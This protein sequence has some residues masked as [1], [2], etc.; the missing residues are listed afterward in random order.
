MIRCLIRSLPLVAVLVAACGPAV[1]EDAKSAAS[2]MAA[3]R[4]VFVSGNF[5]HDK[6][7][8]D[9]IGVFKKAAD[10]GYTG[11][12]LTDCKFD[13]WNEK[14]TVSQPQYTNNVK[15]LCKG[16]RDLGLQI[17]VNCCGQGA[18]LLSNEPNLAEGMPVKDAPFLAKGGLLVPADEDYKVRNPSFEEVGRD[19]NVPVGWN[20]DFPGKCGFVDKD[21]K[22][23][24]KQSVRYE[25][26]K[27]NSSY[28]N[29]RVIQAI[30]CK[31][32]RYYHVSF[33]VKTQDFD[34]PR[35]FNAMALGPKQCLV[36]QTF[37]IKP[38]QDWTKIDIVFNTLDNTQAGLYI[39][40]WGGG[41]GK[42]WIDDVR[43]EAGGFVNLLRRDSLA[44]KI[45]S[46]DGQTVYE[47]GKDYAA[48]KD[49][50][51][52]NVKWPG[53]YD[54]WHEGPK[55]AI[56]AGSRLKDGQKVLA[57]YSH[58]MN[59]LGWGVFACMNE[60]RVSALMKEQVAMIHKVMEPDAYMLGHDEIRHQGWDDS[61]VKSGKTMS[62]TLADNVRTCLEALRKEDPGK[63]I[64]A[65][66][67]MFDPNHNAAKT[68]GPY[69]L[70]KGIDPWY[71]AWEGLDKDVIILNWMG[72]PAKR[73]ASLK[74]FAERG[75]KQ[76][77]AGYY[78]APPEN[79]VP[80]LKDAA[81]VPGVQGVM[82]TTWAN[83][84]SQLEK[85]GKLAREFKAEGK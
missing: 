74:F 1:A 54:Y 66:N 77:L 60:P 50:K 7:V 52:G 49:P 26:I 81:G 73:V 78:D 10:A 64:Y 72:D 83:D 30:E 24:G 31:P 63:P 15:R 69:Y 4:L 38:T 22:S 65:W 46:E 9:A 56:P 5:M 84:F 58:S 14:V 35:S 17:I 34:A 68:G 28:T 41:K 12:L 33:M 76:I 13:R 25:D 6:D 71:G 85:F 55:V 40:S 32:F 27:T 70:V 20:I 62:Q 36:H 21:V 57:T 2:P 79:I 75:H 43:V 23:D 29:G 47:E 8:D 51:T 11:V 44:F 37:E 42:L 3:A 82:Y 16:A 45:A 53:D 67:D 19:P 48:V 59:T 18:D 80:W 39:G 61:C